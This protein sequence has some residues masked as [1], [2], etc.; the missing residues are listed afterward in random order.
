MRAL[1]EEVTGNLAGV[2]AILDGTQVHIYALFFQRPTDED[3]E[4]IELAATSVMADY[5][6]P[7]TI[8]THFGLISDTPRKG[9][10]WIFLRAE[11]YD[12]SP[13]EL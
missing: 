7:F 12:D 3:R 9:I 4:H 5:D 10:P 6:A 8:E 11:A 2:Y 13:H 1:V